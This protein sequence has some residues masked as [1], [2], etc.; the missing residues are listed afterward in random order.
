MMPHSHVALH[1]AAGIKSHT[2][3]DQQAGTTQLDG[4]LSL[5]IVLLHFTAAAS[6]WA[7]AL[8]WKLGEEAQNLELPEG[9]K[10]IA[11]CVL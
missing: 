3:N 2:Y 8:Q 9:H 4:Q 7:G 1:A 11:S 6:D 5:G 10:V